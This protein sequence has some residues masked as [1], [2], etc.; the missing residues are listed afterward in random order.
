MKPPLPFA[1]MNGKKVLRLLSWECQ[2]DDLF[3]DVSCSCR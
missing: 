2:E 3:Y 1:L